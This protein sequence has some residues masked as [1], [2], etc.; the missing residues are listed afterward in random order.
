MKKIPNT[1]Q[2]IV[3]SFREITSVNVE[4][5]NYEKAYVL[6]TEGISAQGFRTTRFSSYTHKEVANEVVKRVSYFIGLK[7]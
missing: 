6:S 3:E 1:F 7:G 2:E 4:Y 5:S